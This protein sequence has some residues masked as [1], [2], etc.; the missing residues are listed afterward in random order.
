M[1]RAHN[2]S[3]H[4]ASVG[5]TSVLHCGPQ[6]SRASLPVFSSPSCSSLPFSPSSH[7]HA[8]LPPRSIVTAPSPDS[9]GGHLFSITFARCRSHVHRDKTHFFLF[10]FLQRSTS[11]ITV[12]T[13]SFV[14]FYWRTLLNDRCRSP[15]LHPSHLQQSSQRTSFSYDATPSPVAR[16]PREAYVC[17]ARSRRGS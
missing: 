4:C 3:P 6:P 1:T 11:S 10:L 17:E 9:L 16:D 7:P 14:A 5:L 15:P 13:S 2:V 8:R 12:E